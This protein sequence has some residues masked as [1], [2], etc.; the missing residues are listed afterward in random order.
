MAQLEIARYAKSTADG[1][2][3]ETRRAIKDLQEIA[4]PIAAAV[5]HETRLAQRLEDVQQLDRYLALAEEH[6]QVAK[7]RAHADI[8]PALA[9]TMRPWV[10]RVTAGRYL[11]LIVEPEDLQLFAFDANG[12]KVE[13]DILSHG[14][15]EQL[16]LLLRIALAKHLSRADESV[17]L[18]LD[19]VTV[20]ADP[21]RTLAILELLLALSAEQ[22]VV[23]FTQEPEVVQWATE[24]LSPNGVVAL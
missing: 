10:P 8:A 17:P 15:T 5:E 2:V 21:Q 24:K 6:L 1:N 12:R 7:E 20:Q 22:Q 3:Q 11:D 13:A 23:L 16:F 4:K 9:D 19:D 18:V 14:T